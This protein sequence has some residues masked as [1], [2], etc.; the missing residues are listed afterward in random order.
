MTEPNPSFESA[1]VAAVLAQRSREDHSALVDDLVALLS[2][3]V[4]G[5]VVE[6]ALLRRHVRA[7]RMPLG[8]FVYV[9]ER[10]QGNAYQASRQ[11][12]VRGVIIRTDPMPI[13]EFLAELGSALDAELRR[14]ERGRAALAEWLN[15]T[16]H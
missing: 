8:E 15:S 1:S 12:A 7:V 10:A 2:E 16:N 13:E 4:P 14:T 11:Y 6:R 5:V 9:L 3:I